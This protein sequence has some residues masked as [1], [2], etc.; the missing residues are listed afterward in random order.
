MSTPVRYAVLIERS[1]RNFSAYAPDLPGCVATGAS[2]EE[3]VREM[4]SV[5]VL[6]VESLRDHGEQVPEPRC[7]FATVDVKAVG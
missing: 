5:I 2:A 6:H 4:R 3:V 7:S 1:R